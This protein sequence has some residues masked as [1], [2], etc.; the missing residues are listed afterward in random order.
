VLRHGGTDVGR[1]P[2]RAPAPAP[3]PTSSTSCLTGRPRP[4]AS[5][6]AGP[7]PRGG[8]GQVPG[9]RPRRPQAERSTPARRP[10]TT[11]ARPRTPLTPLRSATVCRRKKCPP[12][13]WFQRSHP[14]ASH[15][16]PECSRPGKA[17][18]ELACWLGSSAICGLRAGVPGNA[19]RW[20]G[21]SPPHDQPL[22]RQRSTRPPTASSCAR[23]RAARCGRGVWVSLGRER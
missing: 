22:P 21:R 20:P 14:V 2:A 5:D 9:C 11:A 4:G 15:R 6:P 12:A 8:P 19:T 7:R 1:L 3:S 17:V 16:G 10:A 13:R 23:R 18:R